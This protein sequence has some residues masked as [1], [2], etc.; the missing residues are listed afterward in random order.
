M[1]LYNDLKSLDEQQLFT[2]MLFVLYKLSDDPNYS[3][4]SKLSYALD[5]E[6][7]LNLCEI[8]GGTCVRIPT[9]EEVNHVAKAFLLFQY[10]NID[11][12][13]YEDAVKKV[14]QKDEDSTD[15]T[16][17]YGDL[18]KILQGYSFGG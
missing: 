13:E 17:I 12:M 6:S 9:L 5:K 3:A 8:F 14:F 16:V 10:I 2:T 11:K 4:M 18:C 15:V 7:F 1:S